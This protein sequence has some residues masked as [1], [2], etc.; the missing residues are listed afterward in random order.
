MVEKERQ[1]S[2]IFWDSMGWY[3][4][5]LE[6]YGVVLQEST[7]DPNGT[8]G[9]VLDSMAGARKLVIYVQRQG[10]T[11]GCKFSFRWAEL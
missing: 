5:L 4:Y 10:E 1:S 8:L 6:R 3:F 7:G 2:I 9:K 11:P